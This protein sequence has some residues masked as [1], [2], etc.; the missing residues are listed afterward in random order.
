MQ[1]L[2]RPSSAETFLV[3]CFFPEKLKDISSP[4]P[5]W[6]RWGANFP[7]TTE[8]LINKAG[9]KKL[10]LVVVFTPW[11]ETPTQSIVLPQTVPFTY[12]EEVGCVFLNWPTE[13][14]FVLTS[15]GF[16]FKLPEVI[17]NCT[18]GWVSTLWHHFYYRCNVAHATAPG[19]SEVKVTEAACWWTSERQTGTLPGE[20][21][22]PALISMIE[23]ENVFQPNKRQ[24]R[25][26]C[27][28]RGT[29]NRESNSNQAVVLLVRLHTLRSQLCAW[30]FIK[31]DV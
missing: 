12:R 11:R 1:W 10:L 2:A 15:S 22:D 13:S 17:S 28:R 9:V 3:Q 20:V 16:T 5:C 25:K 26:A 6:G 18:P 23:T 31:A 7:S 24:K 4:P 14:R 19:R 27:Y 30:W 29:D 21:A 8:K